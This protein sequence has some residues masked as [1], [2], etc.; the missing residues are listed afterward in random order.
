MKGWNKFDKDVLI[1]YESRGD[2]ACE[3]SG[4]AQVFTY[5]QIRQIASKAFKAGVASHQADPADPQKSSG[6]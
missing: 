6:G 2:D 1:P 4:Y 3:F 5:T